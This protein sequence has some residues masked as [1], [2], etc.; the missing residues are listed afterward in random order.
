MVQQVFSRPLAPDPKPWQHWKRLWVAL[1]LLCLLFLPAFAGAPA[2]ADDC[3]REGDR[4]CTL[5]ERIPS[6]DQNLVEG[7][8]RCVRPL[9]GMQGQGA[10]T[11]VQRMGFDFLLKLPVPQP[12]DANLV[13][14]VLQNKCLHPACGTEGANACNVL[15]RIPSC[16]TNLF[17]RN[18]TCLRPVCGRLGTAPCSID[19][20]GPL[21]V[22]D[23]N[24]IA[25][26][27]QCVRPPGNPAVATSS[28]P[29]PAPTAAVPV[30]PA[31]APHAATPVA[32]SPPAPRPGAA[33]PPP[34]PRLAGLPSIPAPLPAM[35]PP[36]VHPAAPQPV[37]PAPVPPIA[38]ANNGTEMG[39]DRLGSDMYGFDLA[40][41]EP[42]ACQ[43]SCG[44]N[45]Q[46]VAW[47]YVKPGVKGP[48]PRCYL[49]NAAPNPTPND[50]CVSGL[51]N[52]NRMI[53][54]APK[55]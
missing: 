41:A 26:G 49:K 19:V 43:A 17:E 20:R 55:R 34:P 28:A 24:L 45:A 25:V 29:A 18:G 52:R 40:Q 46:C 11:V 35:A 50:C 48:A 1:R 33:V 32:P 15:Q 5:T 53:L 8:G 12:C 39:M 37:P 2:W 38:S 30:A 42:A 6:C 36:V 7:G 3:G 27:G 21:R 23:M 31:P 9:C 44:Y 10:C 13:H 22:C 4:A 14:D 54:I 16:D 47:T 51:A